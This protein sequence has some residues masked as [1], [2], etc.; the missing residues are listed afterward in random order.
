M[1]AM[2]TLQRIPTISTEGD[3]RLLQEMG[4]DAYRFS[5]SWPRILPNGT[6]GDINEKG[7]DY[8]NNLI[9]LMIDNGIE[10]YVTLFHWDTPQAL[11]EDYGGFLDKRI[12]KDYTDFAG[13]CFE[14]FGDRVNNWLTFNEPHTFSPGL[15]CPDPNGN[16][17]KEPYLVGHNILLA[18]AETVHLYNRLTIATGNSNC[19][20]YANS[21]S[22]SYLLWILKGLGS[23][24]LYA[25]LDHEWK[26]G[27]SQ[28]ET[29]KFVVKVVS[30]AM[31]RDGAS[32]GLSVQILI[33]ADGVKRN[34][35]PRQATPVA[36]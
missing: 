20:Y 16:S 27:M 35:Y 13:L 4:M 30:L 12:I 1:G 24:Y 3:V 21:L 26:E 28:E 25:L 33:N 34:F 23:S 22:L 14:R 9:D 5:I 15:K 7:I 31:A 11:V 8:Y 19:C 32:G 10:P 6:L 17:I 18:H 36:R 29:E 2:G